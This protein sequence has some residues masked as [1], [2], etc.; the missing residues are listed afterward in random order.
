VNGFL[1]DLYLVLLVV[2][3]LYV[4]VLASIW[5]VSGLRFS[6]DREKGASDEFYAIPDEDLP[7]M[8]V[9]VPG[10]C[11]ENGITRCLDSLREVDY[12]DLEVIAIDDGSTDRTAEKMEEAMWQDPRLRVIRKHQNEGKAMAMNDAL[13]VARGELIVVV[14]ADAVVPP[15]TFR[16]MAAHFVRVPRVGGVTGNPRPTNLRNLLTEMQVVEYAS[17]VSLMRRAQVVW[18]RV[19]TVSGVVSCFRRGVLAEVGVFDPSMATEDIELTWRVQ[20]SFFDVRYEPRAVIGMSVPATLGALIEQ[21][22]RW[23]RGLAQVLRKHRGVLRHWRNRRHWS[24]FAEATAALVWWHL[25]VPVLLIG[26]VLEIAGYVGVLQITPIPW[27]WV[28]IVVTIALAQLGTGLYLDRRYDRTATGALPLIPLYPMGYW[29][30]V[31]LTGASVAL[32]T[33]L[34]K[35]DGAVERWRPNRDGS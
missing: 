35:N 15:E 31:G 22:R 27:G 16:F 4:V 18:G 10:Y 17:N 6:L 23:G 11:E 33:L 9:L 1:I 26:I 34:G 13:S 8:T 21:R 3:S 19:L 5:I 2:L 25:L 20:R 30:L 28:A 14:D 32:P 7:P 29:I 24:V 12:P